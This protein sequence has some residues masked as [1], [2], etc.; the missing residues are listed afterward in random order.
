MIPE[1]RPQL[2]TQG[3]NGP[4]GVAFDGDGNL[5]CAEEGAGAIVKVDSATGKVKRYP[6]DGLPR[7]IAIDAYGRVWFADCFH[8]A[9]RRFDPEDE[10]CRIMIESASEEP[11]NKPQDLLFDAKGN[12]IFTCLSGKVCCARPTGESEIIANQLTEPWSLSMIGSQMLLIVESA[13]HIIWRGEWHDD[14]CIWINE[15]IWA[16]NLGK[17]GI[18][19]S[20]CRGIDGRHYLTIEGEGMIFSL[21]H[22]GWI[23]ENIPVLPHLPTSGTFDPT[24]ALGFVFSDASRGQLLSIAGLGAGVALYDAG[25]AWAL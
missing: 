6:V 10:T 2:I 19:T 23:T 16:Q 15:R 14:Q 17:K 18:P 8:H 20:V 25:H 4:R 24:G 3:L 21:N 9:I 5:W 11:L 12:I 13:R 22:D 1:L 7:G